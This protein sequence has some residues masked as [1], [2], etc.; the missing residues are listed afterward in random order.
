[1]ESQEKTEAPLD[2]VSTEGSL[3]SDAGST[4]LGVASSSGEFSAEAPST[5]LEALPSGQLALFSVETSQKLIEESERSVGVFSGKSLRKYDP[6]KYHMILELLANDTISI[7]QIAILTKASR[8]LVSAIKQTQQTEIEP[9]RKKIGMKFMHLSEACA[10]RALEMVNDPNAS[11]RLSELAIAGGT[12][13]DKAQLAHGGPTGI[14]GTAS[15]ELSP[16]ELAE[17]LVRLKARYDQDTRSNA[18]KTPVKDLDASDVDVG[19]A[20]GGGPG[21]PDEAEADAPGGP[22]GAQD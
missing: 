1:M 17:Q 9:L 2:G 6:D 16:E 5:D 20:P 19:P 11:I 18:G 4:P 10:E 13:F 22:N 14:T 21:Q 15:T 8:N 7:R 12:A 3:T